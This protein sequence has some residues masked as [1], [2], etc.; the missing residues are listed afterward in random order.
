MSADERDL[1]RLLLLTDRSQLRLGRGLVRTVRE[2]A[3]VGL[4]H[5]VVREHDLVP[6]ARSALVRALAD[7]P[8]LDVITSRIPDP[9]AVGIHLPADPAGSAVSTWSATRCTAGEAARTPRYR[10][11]GRSCHS[12]E[13]VR[14]AAADGADYVTFS[15]FAKSASKPG[16]GPPVDPEAFSGGVERV[17]GVGIP[18]FA[19]GGITVD[20]AASARAVGAHGVAVMGEVMRSVDPAETTARLLAAIG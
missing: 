5:V 9:V 20:N 4:T 17:H 13:E 12:A 14:R 8:G 10:W 15:P 2:C 18:V 11:R 1:P 19:L 6:D 16:H 7:V 3:E